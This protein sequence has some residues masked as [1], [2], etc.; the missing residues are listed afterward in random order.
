MS[1][2]NVTDPTVMMRMRARRISSSSE[3]SESCSDVIMLRKNKSTPS[4]LAIQKELMFNPELEDLKNAVLSN[5]AQRR[6]SFD[7]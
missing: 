4:I 3:S 5:L 1:L 2:L 6:A 7:M